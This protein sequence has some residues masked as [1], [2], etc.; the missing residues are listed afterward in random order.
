M[1]GK[2]GDV[3]EPNC[4]K[5]II[6]EINNSDIESSLTIFALQHVIGFEGDCGMN[7]ETGGMP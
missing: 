2:K 7:R 5:I 1:A 6:I 3:L 4:C